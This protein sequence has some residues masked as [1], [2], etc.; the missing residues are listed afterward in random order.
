MPIHDSRELCKL[1]ILID[2]SHSWIFQIP[3]PHFASGFELM[4]RV[5]SRTSEE[6]RLLNHMNHPSHRPDPWNPAPYLLCTLDRDEADIYACF[7]E[8]TPYDQPPF[9]TVAHY[10]DFFRQLLEVAFIGS[11]VHPSE[12]YLNT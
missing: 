5:V 6:L 4:V 7:E 12:P 10:L 8:L 2:N 3:I 11:H 1:Y 9:R